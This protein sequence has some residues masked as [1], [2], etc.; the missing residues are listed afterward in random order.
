MST[1]VV[2]RMERLRFSRTVLVFQVQ[3]FLWGEGAQ[4][5]GVVCSLH[6]ISDGVPS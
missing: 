5:V 6:K 1:T 3:R 2:C 4:G